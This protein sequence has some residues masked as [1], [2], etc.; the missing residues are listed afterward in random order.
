MPSSRQVISDFIRRGYIK[1]KQINDALICTQVSPNVDSWFKFIE[2]LL[3]CLGAL[4]L[5]F[6]TLFF[7][8]Y[9]WNE[10]GQFTKFALLESLLVVVIFIYWRSKQGSIT[11]QISL[12][13]SCLLVGI[14]MAFFGQTYQTGADPWTLFFF[15]AVLITPWVIIARF[16]PLWLSWLALLNVALSLYIDSFGSPFFL[17]LS[18]ENEIWVAIFSL[19]SVALIAL[20]LS[21]QRFN[22][23]S[24]RW[25]ARIIASF[26]GVM[27]TLTLIE[28]IISSMDTSK[29]PLLLWGIFI[30]SLYVIYRHFRADLFMLAGGCLS[31]IVIIVTFVIQQ[32]SH[33]FNEG[34]LLIISLLIIGLTSMATYWLK[35]VHKEML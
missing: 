3:L 28:N 14:L 6:S 13:V 30:A 35:K 18:T 33:D 21:S 20:E 2:R 17:I 5:G 23:L 9:N 16:A 15:W 31:S 1:P 19:N 25:V 24:A 34:L 29:L 32:F 27:I 26:A 11:A 12:L 8:A 10:F 7:I 4:S 22:Y